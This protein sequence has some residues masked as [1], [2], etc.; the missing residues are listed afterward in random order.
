MKKLLIVSTVLALF[1]CICS[2]A[3]AANSKTVE[4]MVDGIKLESNPGACVIG[5][6]TYVPM[7]SLCQALR[8]DVKQDTSSAT[9]A[10]VITRAKT[11]REIRLEK[12]N[13]SVKVNGIIKTI[14]VQP[15]L[16]AFNQRAGR[17][18]VMVP[19]T[20]V[21]EQLGGEATWNSNTNT[22]LINSYM[23]IS[24]NDRKL[25]AAIRAQVHV[26]EGN[27]Y[28]GDVSSIQKL[29]IVNQDVLKIDGLEYMVNLNYLDLTNN[30]IRDLTPLKK[31]NKLSALF[32]KGN[33]VEDYSPIVVLYNKLK[34]KDFDIKISFND[35]N[36]ENAVKEAVGK[37]NGELVPSDLVAIKELDLSDKG[38]KSL[39]G[40]QYFVN[41]V[42]LDMSGNMI[43]D[44]E[45]L[46]TLTKMKTLL[47]SS[48]LLVDITPLQYLSN[49]EYLN[50]DNNKVYDLTPLLQVV[51]LKQLS[52]MQN[53]IS[54]TILIGKLV[55]LEVLDLSKNS[56]FEVTGLDKLVKLK[57]LYLNTNFISDISFVGSMINLEVLDL[58]ENRITKIDALKKLTSLKA[59]YLNVNSISDISAIGDLIYLKI[60]DLTENKITEVSGLQNLV[61]LTR[62]YLD[63]NQ[64]SDYSPLKKYFMNLKEKDF[65]LGT[66]TDISGH[67][68][69]SYIEKL[70]KDG[71][72][73]GYSDGTIR[74]DAEI[75]RVEIVAILIKARGITPS[76]SSKLSFADAK[77]IPTWAASSVQ[78]AVENGIVKGFSDNTFRPNQNVSRTEMIAMVINTFLFGKA[79]SNIHRFADNSEIQGWA[80]GYIGKAYELGLS[81]GYSD[82][83]FKP[84]RNVARAEAFVTIVNALNLKKKS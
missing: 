3:Y 6:A 58:G 22:I 26:P 77:D 23:P 74:P 14:E 61:G 82:N 41:L 60:L 55:E 44:L 49:L 64:I 71:V 81:K 57:E 70:A 68:A 84:N 29:T 40:T 32:L 56:I 63:G 59:L 36:L 35:K 12:G 19:L 54:N 9:E 75:T 13:K 65:K 24:F 31:L 76:S 10:Y 30:N 11:S 25:E 20:F 39:Q 47:L 51:H 46:R 50:L 8:A 34:E 17:K 7:L 37:K 78:T 80:K 27:I 79:D 48:N 28:K 4:V 5:D 18:E 45:P 33:F 83:T 43:E 72:I 73:S 67:W 16:A 38:I 1:L 69:R 53:N 42:R 21:V 2:F 52:L 66:F 15:I 62:L